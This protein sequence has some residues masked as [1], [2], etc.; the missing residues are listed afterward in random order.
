MLKTR[1]LNPTDL[2]LVRELHDKY[3][4]DQFKLPD[5]TN[6]LG[7]F[8]ITNEE[9]KLIMAGGV[10][11]IGESLL[12]TDKEHSSKTELG[13]A[14]VIAQDI[15]RYI[16]YKNGIEWLHAFVKD[17]GY[18]RHLIKHGFNPRCQALSMKV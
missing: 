4:G 1:S 2:S 9:D 6:M 3:F 14:L 12:V 18:A 7:A 17:E 8:V 11:T 13:R 5:F 10:R 15:S 16:C